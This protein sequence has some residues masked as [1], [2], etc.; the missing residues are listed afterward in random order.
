MHGRPYLYAPIA[1]AF[2]AASTAASAGSKLSLP[3]VA[4]PGVN[5]T[6]AANCTITVS[7]SEGQLPHAN[8]NKPHT[9][10]LQS[11]TITAPPYDFT[12][13]LLAATGQ[14]RK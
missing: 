13:E 4:A 12:A 2:V 14:Q 10:W 8:L 6:F 1:A 5:C 9:A 3:E 11:R 7:D